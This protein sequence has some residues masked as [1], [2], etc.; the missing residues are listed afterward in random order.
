VVAIH[1]APSG[2]PD[3]QR[4]VIAGIARLAVPLFLVISGFLIGRSRPPQAKL[5]GYF[6]KFVRLHLLYGAF[7]WA[8]E[9]VT[10]GGYRDLAPKNVLMHFAAFAYPGQYYLF[11]LPQ[12][13][14]LF[15]F[16]IPEP[17]RSR[18]VLLAA[19]LLLAAG[20]VAI[21]SASLAS[22]SAA[23]LPA[24]VAGHAEATC[25]LWLF[26]FTAG[27]WIGA[28]EGRAPVARVGRAGS[29]LLAAAATT[30]AVLELPPT[31][32]AL[33]V[34]QFAYAR[35]SILI[36]TA[37]LAGALPW[38]SRSLRLG[39]LEA[40]GRESFGVFVLNPAI[41]ALLKLGLGHAE[42]LSRS[43]LYLAATLAIAYGLTRWLRPRLPFA[44]P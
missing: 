26:A 15:G 7:Y 39:P 2:A 31:D 40:L 23:P 4:Y 30:L 29:L 20:C 21:L 35:W 25:V 11:V 18:T 42:T 38:T 22:G 24:V 14:F 43:L 3:Y 32:G 5:V 27:V 8:L 28:R 19:S 9:P 44:F 10:L 36:G 16:V 17:W 41:L 13:Y 34:K 1:A 33:Y 6:W 12:I 37:L